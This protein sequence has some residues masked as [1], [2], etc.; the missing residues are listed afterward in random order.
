MVYHI[1]IITLQGFNEL[2][3]LV[4]YSLL[5]RMK[6]VDL[7][8]TLCCPEQ[9]VTSMNGVI[10]RGQSTLEDAATAQAVLIG[11]G[12]KTREH[13]AS[14][15]LVSRIKLNPD[16]QLIAAQCSGVWLLSS[17]GL[18]SEKRVC[19]DLSTKPRLQ[20]AGFEVLDQPF[21]AT[22]NM[23]TA[24][25][26]LASMYL[27]AW[28]IARVEGLEA[29]AQALESVAPVGEKEELVAK[30]VLNITPYLLS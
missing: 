27:A 16:K 17:L 3:S 18:L 5:R 28:L 26:C 1:A 19:T 11:S 24:G 29:A 20:E 30:M 7:Q 10:V 14:H 4:A 9:E 21:F 6:T 15:R 12:V 23:A 22:G 25:G 2:D 13:V 8:V